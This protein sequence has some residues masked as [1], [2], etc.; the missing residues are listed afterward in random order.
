MI[1]RNGVGIELSHEEEEVIA[2]GYY[3]KQIASICKDHLYKKYGLKMEEYEYGYMA[4]A[5]MDR[6]D[7]EGSPV[8][9]VISRTAENYE[10]EHRIHQYLVKRFIEGE[11]AGGAIMTGAEIFKEMDL[12]DCYRIDIRIYRIGLFGEEPERC[13]FHGTWHEPGDPLRMTITSEDGKMVY[14][15]GYGTDH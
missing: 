5:V 4:S 2:E 3:K 11:D 1:F 9:E 8:G 6:L 14:D 10:K 13:A 12:S 7:D 15:V